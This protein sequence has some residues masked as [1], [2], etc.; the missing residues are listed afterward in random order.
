MLPSE[1]KIQF[2]NDVLM[3][4]FDSI[5]LDDYSELSLVFLQIQQELE[6]GW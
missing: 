2:S 1:E 5:V 6:E 3:I 4:I